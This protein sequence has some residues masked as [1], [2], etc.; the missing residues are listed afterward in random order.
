MSRCRTSSRRRRGLT[1]VECV[2]SVVIVSVMV[3][4]ALRATG[5]VARTM[6]VQ[7]NRSQAMALA[8]QLMSEIAQQAYVDPGSTPVF[9]P[10]AGESRPTFDDVDDYN[11]LYDSP[12]KSRSNAALVGF[13]TWRW[14]AT[15]EYIDAT[16]FLPVPAVDTGIKRITITV[17]DPTNKVLTLRGLRTSASAYEKTYAGQS[18]YLSWGTVTLQVGSD[19]KAKVVAGVNPVNQIP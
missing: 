1:L 10:E 9:G 17:T 6:V 5:S 16:T 7:Q 18:T 14:Q 3:V 11:G 15:V 19:S 4:A 2:L 12:P 8:R 13:S